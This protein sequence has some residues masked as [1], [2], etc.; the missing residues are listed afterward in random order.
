VISNFP[1]I[2]HKTLLASVFAAAAI[3]HA[4]LSTN[5]PDELKTPP[6]QVILLEFK[7]K[8]M[9]I[10]V[11]KSPQNN[12][13]KSEWIF[14]APE[15]DLYDTSGNIIGHH[16]AG[17]TWESNDGSKVVGELKAKFSAK[18]VTSIPWLLLS[19][20]SN[21]GEGVFTNITSIL[22]IKTEGGQPPALS[23]NPFREGTEVRIPYQAVYLFY[24]LKQ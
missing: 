17:P 5:V 22:R 9:Q 6:D 3:A 15:A 13:L 19:A 18:D 16:Y 12:S 10:Y 14:K 2:I 23:C 20:K 4:Q 1:S 24:G 7:A 21:S 8:G 11:C